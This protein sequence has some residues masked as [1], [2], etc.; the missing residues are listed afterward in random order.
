[1]LT[2]VIKGD[3]DASVRLAAIG[4]LDRRDGDLAR[5]VLEGARGDFDP[6]VREAAQQA[7]RR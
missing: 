6:Q 4:M 7:L 2:Q 3:A 5:A 1:M